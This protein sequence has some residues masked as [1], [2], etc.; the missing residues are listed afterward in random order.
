MKFPFPRPPYRTVVVRTVTLG[1]AAAAV[2]LVPAQAQLAN[3][4]SARDA[5]R[6]AADADPSLRRNEGFIATNGIAAQVNDKIITLDQL[7]QQI[8][9]IVPEI[10]RRS[11][12]REQFEQNIA[13]VTREVLQNLIDQILIVRE[14]EEKG[15]VLPETYIRNEM[16][17]FVIKN[18]NGD[19]S[20]F[21]ESLRQQG[22]NEMAFRN[23]MKDSIVV[24]YMRSQMV[25]SATQVSPEEIN[26]YYQQHRS[27]FYE[28]AGVKLSMIMLS[29]AGSNGQLVEQQVAAIQKG[30][31]EGVAF[32]D[33][34]KKYSQDPNA[35]EGGDWGWRRYSDLRRELATA[36]EQLEAGQVSE[37]I[38]LSGITYII[39]VEEKRDSGVKDLD[40]VRAEIEGAITS[41]LARQAQQRWL[42]RLRKQAYIR[43][44]LEEAGPSPAIDNSP[45]SMRLGQSADTQST[46]NTQEGQPAQEQATPPMLPLPGGMPAADP[47]IPAKLEQKKAEPSFKTEQTPPAYNPATGRLDEGPGVRGSYTP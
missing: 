31:A 19:R 1:L 36:A 25:R 6:A 12:T 32:A 3:T 44:Y 45:V 35:A 38:E 8:V 24:S 41:Q 39:Y 15:Y 42:E 28:D 14:F 17:D 40:T 11:A 29:P 9:P 16:E 33:L 10:R 4:Q 20:R 27:Q 2:A 23:Q 34:A 21:L 5:Q 18:F 7:R 26:Q 46:A 30:L 37:P 47:R 43:Y 13:M 22:T